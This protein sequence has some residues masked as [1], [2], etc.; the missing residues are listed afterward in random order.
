MDGVSGKGLS[1][2]LLMESPPQANASW[3]KQPN[4]LTQWK[5]SSYLCERTTELHGV[6]KTPL[7]Q[8]VS[9]FD[10]GRASFTTF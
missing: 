1:Q 3:R 2:H 9:I 4:S 5:A 6:Q 8:S 7:D 10:S